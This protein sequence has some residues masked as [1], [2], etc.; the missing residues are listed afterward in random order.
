LDWVCN[1]PWEESKWRMEFLQETGSGGNTK[2]ENVGFG[3][4]ENDEGT[5][6]SV[7]TCK[8]REREMERVVRN[9][10]GLIFSVLYSGCVEVTSH[11]FGVASEVLELR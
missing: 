4:V 1:M 3:D 8:C 10:V 9:D 11:V 2:Y 5:K 6:R 7:A